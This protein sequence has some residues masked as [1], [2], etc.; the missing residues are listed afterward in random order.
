MLLQ[1]FQGFVLVPVFLNFIY[2]YLLFRCSVDRA[3]QYNLSN[4][5]T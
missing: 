3:S 4:W 2:L 5:S 1:L